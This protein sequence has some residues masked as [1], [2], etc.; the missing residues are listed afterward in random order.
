M[1]ENLLDWDTETLIY[2]NN[3]GSSTYDPFWKL[4]TT[5]STWIPLFVGF[6]ILL[7]V[8]FTKREALG[9]ILMLILLAIAITFL[10]D[11]V[12][13]IFQRLRPNNDGAINTLIRVVKNPQ[14]FSFFSGHAASSFSITTL[15]ILFIRKQTKWIWLSLIWPFLFAYSRIYLGVH[16][17]LDIMVGAI[18]GILTGYLFYRS[19]NRIIQPYLG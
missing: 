7:I 4:I 19:Y 3:L 17:P 1:F 18:I 8:K 2:L 13:D 16:F 10:T 11:V 15:A 5:I 6:G 14:S 12:K 9:R